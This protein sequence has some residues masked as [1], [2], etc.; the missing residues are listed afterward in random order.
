MRSRH[1]TGRSWL[2]LALCTFVVLVSLLI[3]QNSVAETSGKSFKIGV[4]APRTGFG[5]SWFAAGYPG[6]Q[7]AQEEI[8]ASGG[9]N[10]VPV[11]FLVY[12]TATKPQEAIQ[13]MQKL[14]YTDKVLAIIGPSTSSECEVVFPIAMRAKIT[15]VGLLSAEPGVSAKYR[16]WAFRNTLTSDKIYGPLVRKWASQNQVKTAAIIYDK[17]SAFTK[18]DG[19]KVFPAALESAGIKLLGSVTYLTG[20]TDFSAQI[21]KIK[22]WNP[23]GLILASFGAEGGL[24]V[25]E[26][27]KQDLKVALVG[28]IDCN[29]LDFVRLAGSAADGVWTSHSYWSD[30]PDPK[31]QRVMK[32]AKAILGDK[33]PDL[34]TDRYYDNA[35]IMYYLI[36]KMGVTNRPEDLES[37]REKLRTGWETLKDFPGVEGKITINKD[38]DGEKSSYIFVIKGGKYVNIQK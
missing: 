32:R 8:N 25:R 21:T 38:G 9:V 13:M 20:D 35:M 3:V 15:S 30:N 28:G 10:G 7:V 31:V 14:T 1:F 29:A 26:C 4:L 16:P 24:I 34:T 27:K 19:E 12:D 18:A 23:D 17:K 6:L 11:E 33:D 37:D 36:K 2:G 22:M 5:A